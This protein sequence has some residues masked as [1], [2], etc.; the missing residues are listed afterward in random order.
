MI[1]VSMRK[2]NRNRLKIVVGN[3]RLNIWTHIGSAWIDDDAF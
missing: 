2:K 1:K 3:D